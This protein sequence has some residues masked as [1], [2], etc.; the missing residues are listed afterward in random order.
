M[1]ELK[2]DKE[3]VILTAA[4]GVDL[5]IMKKEDYIKQSEELLNTSTYKKIAEDPTSKQKTRLISILKN[6]KAEGGLK[7]ED[8]RKM[9][10][11]GAV[12]PKYYGLPKIHKPGIPL[13][14]IISSTGTVTYNTAKELAKIL[15]PL[16]GLSSHHVHNTKDFIDHIKEVTSYDMMH[17]PVS[18]LLFPCL[19]SILAKSQR[20]MFKQTITRRGTKV[21]TRN[22][23]SL[24]VPSMGH[25]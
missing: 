8:Y 13:R 7:E 10:P 20:H 21:D 25:K 24:Q 11:T 9:Y 12:S 22:I 18:A 17:S 14:P 3:R 2:K 15:K 19:S 6:I 16:V 4:K 23:T 5:V 1:Q